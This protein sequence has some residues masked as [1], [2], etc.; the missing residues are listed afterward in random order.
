MTTVTD[1]VLYIADSSLKIVAFNEAAKIAFPKLEIGKECLEATSILDTEIN[2]KSLTYHPSTSMT[3][4]N[5]GF[6]RWINFSIAS[7]DYLD[8]GKCFFFTGTFYNSLPRELMSRVEYMDSFNFAVEMNLTTNRY[9]LISEQNFDQPLQ[10]GEEPLSELLKRTLLTM[11]HPDDYKKFAE[12]MNLETMPQRLARAKEPITEVIRE[13]STRG[14]WDDVTIRLIPESNLNKGHQLVMALFFINDNSYKKFNNSDL[15]KDNLTGLFTKNSFTIQAK[16]FLEGAHDE[17]CLIAMDIENFRFFNKWYSRWQGDRLLKNIAYTLHEIDRLFDSVSGYGGGDDFFIIL[18]KHDSVIKYLINHLNDIVSSFDGIEGF[19]MVFGGY[20]IKD[21]NEEILDAID[22]ATT[23]SNHALGKQ[24]LEV[25]WYNANMVEDLEHDLKIIPDIERGLEENEFTF[26]LQPKCSIKDN[27]IVGAEALVRWNSKIHGFV[28]PGDFIPALEKN[29]M[30][31]K[32]D[33]YVWEKVCKTIRN[34]INSGKTPVPISVN[35]SRMDIFAVDVP[36]VFSNLIDIYEIDPKY[37]EIEI[38]ESA[39][40]D[41]TRI[42]RTVIQRLKDKGFSILIDDFGSGYSSLNML[43]DVQ[44]DVLKMDMKFFDLN[45]TNY[46]KGISIIKSVVD[47]SRNMKLPV[48]AEGVETQ[49]QI[50]L[51]KGMGLNYVQGFYY[52]KPIPIEEYEGLI[53]DGNRISLDGLRLD[54]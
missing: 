1:N 26:Y 2:N 45:N 34:W 21:A 7:M 16:K 49:E 50:D 13:K 10:L 3:V 24:E 52:Y 23:A 20:E 46:D 47:L 39:F 43:K 42:L 32:V 14:T 19:R 18:D 35:V 15:E 29:G 44:A 33:V 36:T 12:L 30:V 53:S 17:V 9:A 54:Q 37:V 6:L 5:L 41:D 8:H 27:K 31:M 4:F 22:Y 51:L 11:V 40:I 38:T 28:S 25:D 48:I